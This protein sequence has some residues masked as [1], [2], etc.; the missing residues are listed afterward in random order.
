MS[1]PPSP[2]GG[3]GGAPSGPAGGQL[4]GTYPDPSVIGFTTADLFALGIG[5]IAD[6]KFLKRVGTDIV[7]VSGDAFGIPSDPALK[8]A[9][10]N[11]VSNTA[12]RINVSATFTVQLPAAPADGDL[13]LLIPHPATGV[14]GTISV[15][16]TPNT[17]L[18]LGAVTAT[19]YLAAYSGNVLNAQMWRFDASAGY[20]Q[21]LDNGLGLSL[22]SATG[23]NRVLVS[24]SAGALERLQLQGGMLL[25]VATD[26]SAGLIQRPYG[27]PF[28]GAIHA[29]N[30]LAQIDL[31]ARYDAGAV[32][33]I[34]M[35]LVTG[36]RDNA[37]VKL[38]EAAGNAGNV[39]IQAQV[40]DTI[41]DDTGAFAN[42]ISVSG[43]WSRRTW[44]YDA[45]NLQWWL[46]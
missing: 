40:G 38:I 37:Q 21:L 29:G 33:Q 12:Y 46:V 10:F 13:V 34:D 14:G 8:A 28:D 20:W 15:D 32:G 6:G 25:T 39:T 42:S 41:Q 27:M 30:F 11:A 23:I 18:G 9:N 22:Q 24:A 31:T 43:A 35:P 19:P 36:T 45:S 44:Q 17:I 1:W 4:S 2:C 26:N 3:C 16:A 5:S 7:G